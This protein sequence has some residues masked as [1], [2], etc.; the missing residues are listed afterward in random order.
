[1]K[2]IVLA[3]IAGAIA[4]PALA[5]S[6]NYVQGYVRRDGGYVAPH[7]RT[8]PDNSRT[9]NYSAQGNYNPYTGQAGTVNPY[10]PQRPAY[11]NPYGT[12]RK[13]GF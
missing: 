12:T 7:Y 11:T 3:I 6:N 1:M 9:N 10:A 8:N 2:K 4:V 5:Q 13:R